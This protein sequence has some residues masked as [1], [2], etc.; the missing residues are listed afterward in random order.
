[1]RS[2]DELMPMYEFSERHRV[3][4]AASAAR[5]DQA[6]RDVTLGEVPVVRALCRVRGLR[7][8]RELPFVRVIPRARVVEDVRGEGLVLAVEGAFWRW[9]GGGAGPAAT[10]VVDF[11][12]LPGELATET[13]VHVAD[14]A[15][16]RKFACY[17]VAIRPFSGLIRILVLRAAKRRAERA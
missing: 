3:P 14:H 9:R 15:A 13:R 16:R 11:R 6:I 1:M 4:V 10:A 2:L 17:W 7:V 5:V 12:A 8:P